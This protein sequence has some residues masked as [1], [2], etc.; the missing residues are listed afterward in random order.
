MWS[1][2]SDVAFPV[3]SVKSGELLTNWYKEK[4]AEKGSRSTLHLLFFVC[5]CELP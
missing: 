1:A 5:F 2:A 3:L 4:H